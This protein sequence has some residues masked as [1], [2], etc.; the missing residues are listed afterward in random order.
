MGYF[1][2]FTLSGEIIDFM[3][4]K[5]YYPQL[6]AIRGF[7]FLAVFSYHS[8]HPVFG[9]TMV[10][11]LLHF[12]WDCIFYSIDVFFV[13]SSF[14]LT[15]LGLNELSK[16]GKFSFKN[17]FVRRALRIWPLYYVIMFFS[18]VILP[19]IA[20]YT[21]DSVT[22]PEPKWYL[23]F[24]SN[25]YNKDHV[26]FLRFLWT[27]SV[28]EQFYL[29]LGICL[30]FFQKKLLA[31]T[32]WVLLIS[33]IFNFYGTFKGWDLYFNTITYLYDFCIGMLVAIFVKRQNWIVRRIITLS[34]RQ[35]GRVY[36]LLPGFL[37]VVFL[38]K[39]YTTLFTQDFI[40]LFSK[41]V[42]I[43]FAAFSIIEQIFNKNTPFNFGKSRFLVFTGKRSYG[44]YCFHGIVLT[45]G[46]IILRRLNFNLPEL[47]QAILLL[48]VTYIL[49]SLSYSY[50]E[51]PFIRLKEKVGA[52]SK[53]YKP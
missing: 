13:L 22:L 47:I 48:A 42:F 31:I 17:Y 34:P 25:F 4:K 23:L 11:Q 3:E 38:L 7:F 50:F 46:G 52:Y 51:S 49:A 9:T 26:Y 16:S 8:Y 12:F 36:T 28:E 19:T 1:P 41:L 40:Q 43:L 5:H 6:D 20:K 14:L 53:K 29:A 10:S 24:I 15:W 18:F 27:L 32:T 37:I 35:I 45:F 39:T 33:I 30:T 2:T 44:L 21:H